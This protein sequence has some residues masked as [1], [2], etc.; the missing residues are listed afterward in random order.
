MFPYSVRFPCKSRYPATDMTQVG[1]IVILGLMVSSIRK[2]ARQLGSTHVVQGHIEKR[3]TQT[4]N[5]SAATQREYEQMKAQQLTKI[6]NVSRPALPAPSDKGRPAINFDLDKGPEP[7]PHHQNSHRRRPLKAGIRN[8]RRTGSRK[9]KI[10]M[11]KE[12]KDRFYAMRAIQ[13]STSTF[14]RYTALTMSII[15]C[16]F[17]IV[18]D[19]F[20][21]HFLEC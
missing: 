7:S 16:K 10:L 5:N 17:L 8:L 12:E 18:N 15:A 6:N 20:N 3:R 21:L 14:K 1:G 11:L 19:S 13:R 4:L 9:P 2:F